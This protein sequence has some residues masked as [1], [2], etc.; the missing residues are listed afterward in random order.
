MV[1]PLEGPGVYLIWELDKVL[2]TFGIKVGLVFF[3]KPFV[4]KAFFGF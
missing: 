4:P 2:I 1:R 3:G